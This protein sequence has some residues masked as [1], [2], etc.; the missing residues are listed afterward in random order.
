MFRK[1]FIVSLIVLLF[2]G[3]AYV[4]ASGIQVLDT[5]VT[6]NADK[7]S[8]QVKFTV[9]WDHSWRLSDGPANYDAAWVFVKYRTLPGDNWN[10]AY[11]ATAGTSAPPTTH[12]APTNAEMK[13]GNSVAVIGGANATIGVGAF[14]YRKDPGNGAISFEDVELNWDFTKNGLTGGEQVEVCVLATEMVFI[15]AGAFWLGD[16]TSD[17]RFTRNRSQAASGLRA[18]AIVNVTAENNAY[19][20]YFSNFWNYYGSTSTTYQNFRTNLFNN[21]LS[22]AT[23]P[24]PDDANAGGRVTNASNYTEGTWTSYSSII[25]ANNP[26]GFNAFFC[27][28]YEI[29]QGEYLQFLNKNLVAVKNAG[30]YYPDVQTTGR[31]DIVKKDGT[32][33]ATIPAEYEFATG[34][35][36]SAYL[37]CGYL[38]THDIYGWLIW[39]GLRPMSEMEFEKA[40]RGPEAIPGTA[41]LRPQYAWG[42]VDIYNA[43]GLA[44]AGMANEAP[45]N[46]DGNCAVAT[47]V[48]TATTIGG[49]VNDNLAGPIRSAGFSTPVSSRIKS[50]AT[51]YGVMEMS[52]NLWERAISVGNDA[53]R[54]FQGKAVTAHGNGEIGPA[55]NPD[56]PISGGWPAVGGAGLGFRGGSYM[57]QAIRARI[58]DRYFINVVGTTRNKAFGGR[59][60]RSAL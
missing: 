40:C 55:T 53:G 56:L 59:G 37:P 51:Y 9:S 48:G 28:K 17:G 30:Y 24:N 32:G 19:L 42:A 7:K 45:S 23:A 54:A 33:T 44:N 27:M 35:A 13:I 11:I 12:K 58:S 6:T 3:S 49:G 39:A 14:I 4:F 26:R 41:S 52:G 50:G 22:S 25:N 18:E 20:V 10:H 15:P 16:Y 2:A 5:E 46:L 36:T 38:N 21:T 1:S 57:D 34:K 47:A 31:F 29:T 60:V 43:A 8:A